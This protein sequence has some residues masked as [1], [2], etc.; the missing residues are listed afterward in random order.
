MSGRQ[1]PDCPQFPLARSLSSPTPAPVSTVWSLLAHLSDGNL[2]TAPG[3]GQCSWVS[4]Q[5]PRASQWLRFPYPGH[6]MGQKRCREWRLPR[7]SW[8]APGPRVVERREATISHLQ[9]RW[10]SRVTVTF[11][12]RGFFRTI[13]IFR[14]WGIAHLCR[15]SHSLQLAPLSLFHSLQ[16]S[17]K[18][19]GAARRPTPGGRDNSRTLPSALPNAFPSKQAFQPGLRPHPSPCLQRGRK[20]F[21]GRAGGMGVVVVCGVLIPGAPAKVKGCHRGGR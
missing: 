15:G 17:S 10:S 7:C 19:R 1:G 21:P 6:Q 13:S 12:K 3:G 4:S 16:H 14:T 8:E 5:V 11:L 2:S 9:A 18:A 20:A